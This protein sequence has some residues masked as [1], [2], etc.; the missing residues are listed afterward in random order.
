MIRLLEG[1]GYYQFH[2]SSGSA[3]FGVGVCFFGATTVGLIGT[4]VKIGEWDKV[5]LFESSSSSSSNR[6]TVEVGD[7]RLWCCCEGKTIIDIGLGL[8]FGFTAGEDAAGGGDSK[9]EDKDPRMELDMPV[10]SEM[11]K[12]ALFACFSS[13]RGWMDKPRSQ[14]SCRSKRTTPAWNLQA[15]YWTV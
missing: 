4:G 2:S 9:T 5:C 10:T 14:R 6:D 11:S 1:V 12:D 7:R 15:K 8:G 3:T 13:L